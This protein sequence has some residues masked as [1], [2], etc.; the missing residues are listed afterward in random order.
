MTA[1]RRSNNE[2][3]SRKIIADAIV[4]ARG[5]ATEAARLIRETYGTK[6]PCDR[7]VRKR[8]AKDPGLKALQEEARERLLDIAETHMYDKVIAGDFRAESYLLNTQGK[9]RGYGKNY[10]QVQ[11]TVRTVKGCVEMG[12]TSEDQDA[13]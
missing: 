10:T 1:K 13:C 8:I 11:A 4:K 2:Q 12:I 9:H 7:E 6:G 5:N 3:W